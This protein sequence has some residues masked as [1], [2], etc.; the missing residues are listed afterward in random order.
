MS[1]VKFVNAGPIE[2]V[3]YA[4][5]MMTVGPLL[6]GAGNP[7]F[8]KPFNVEAAAGVGP[9]LNWEAPIDAGADRSRTLIWR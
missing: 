2:S 1:P 9:E 8:P 4:V 3:T 5:P 7:P 6:L